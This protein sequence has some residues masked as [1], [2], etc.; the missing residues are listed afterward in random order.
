MRAT[1]RQRSLQLTEQQ[2]LL[3]YVLLGHAFRGFVLRG[4]ALRKH[5]SITRHT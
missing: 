4:I 2:S 1:D 5:V 3:D